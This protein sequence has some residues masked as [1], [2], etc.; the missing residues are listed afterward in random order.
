MTSKDFVRY[1]FTQIYILAHA[2]CQ[3]PVFLTA[4]ADQSTMT[5]RKNEEQL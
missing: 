4:L 1:I 5:E 2:R 3:Q